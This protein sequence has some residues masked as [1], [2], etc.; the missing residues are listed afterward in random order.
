M[1]KQP[2]V[3]EPLSLIPIP[4]EPQNLIPIPS[5]NPIPIPMKDPIPVQ[6]SKTKSPI[7]NHSENPIP[8][9]ESENPIPMP[10]SQR[11][12]P[13]PSVAMGTGPFSY[14]S[15]P[16]SASQHSQTSRHSNT[17]DSDFISLNDKYYQWEDYH[18]EES[19]DE[20]P[21]IMITKDMPSPRD[22]MDVCWLCIRPGSQYYIPLYFPFIFMLE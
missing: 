13:M 17:L 22:D 5:E 12:V 19:D 10:T 20:A 18:S 8:I 4:P 16:H 15:P 7:S 9:P 3:H 14:T 21:P 1:I 2:I 11:Q 6:S